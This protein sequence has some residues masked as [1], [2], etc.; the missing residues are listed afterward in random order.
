MLLPSLVVLLGCDPDPTARALRVDPT[1]DAESLQVVIAASRVPASAT[2][3]S[4]TG[5]P[6]RSMLRTP[7][8]IVTV[9]PHQ[10]SLTLV[11]PDGPTVEVPVGPSPAGLAHIDDQLYVTLEHGRSIAVLSTTDPAA[12]V[13]RT[14][15]VGAGPTGI[16]AHPAGDRIYVALSADRAVVELALP[17]L[18]E[19]FRVIL[20]ETPRFL[21]LAPA[22]DRLVI[23][24]ERG[25]ARI[26]SVA[27]GE[28]VTVDTLPL[29]T[30]VRP[31]P[32]FTQGIVDERPLTARVTGR[33]VFDA[34]GDLL[35]PTLWADTVTAVPALSS[36]RE[37]AALG[38][39]T[40]GGDDLGIG[41]LNPAIT[42]WTSEGDVDVHLLWMGDA[43]RAD[44]LI[45]S[46]PTAL[47]VSPAGW[48][49][50]SMESIEAMLVVDPTRPH[51]YDGPPVMAPA[52]NGFAYP[53][54][55]AVDAPAGVDGVAWDGGRLVLH[56]RFTPA[57]ETLD[58]TEAVDALATGD[59]TTDTPVFTVPITD[60]AVLAAPAGSAE[61]RRGRLLFFSAAHDATSSG[62]VSCSTCH[63]NGADDGLT[64]TFT[65]GPRQTP[66]LAG[67]IGGTG[68][69]TWSSDVPTVAEEAVLT[70]R[71]RMG[72]DGPTP[73]DLDAIAAFIDRTPLPPRP[74]ADPALVEAGRL[75]FERGDVGCVTCHDGPHLTH[76]ARHDVL[77]VAVNTPRL[78]G[79][80]ATAPYFHD[81]SAPTL[82]A[83]LDHAEDGAMGATGGLSTSE[84]EALVA[85]LRH[86]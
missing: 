79:V 42:R 58:A 70:T 30:P 45:R 17:D 85:Y 10:G 16:A 71:G 53:L 34:A 77:G 4:G 82:E 67:E 56:D 65:N 14:L 33:P 73:E 5:V 21:A 3:P 64:W 66:S 32:L 52:R 26:R 7:A 27:L 13:L 22:G 59:V 39:N 63:V 29:P 41:R 61:E 6:S 28:E 20:P 57:V 74:T 18:T 37:I 86:R 31:V 75:V 40:Y 62:G 69:F 49:A 43:T 84:R 8:G 76:N 47:A 46:Y 23:A 11:Q 68:P 44:T 81:G 15:E 54:S 24:N 2:T 1:P 72:G 55:V 83:V 50:V 51:R 36:P 9:N 80:A 25:P 12:G 60:R 35:V 48:W 38:E 19:T 78:V